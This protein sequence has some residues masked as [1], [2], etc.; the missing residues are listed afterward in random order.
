MSVFITDVWPRRG[1][2]FIR[3]ESQARLTEFPYAD[4]SQ[5]ARQL[6]AARALAATQAAL[7]SAAIVDNSMLTHVPMPAT[8]AVPALGEGSA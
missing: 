2:S 6:V 4:A 8:V 3:V 1:P 7:E 5:R